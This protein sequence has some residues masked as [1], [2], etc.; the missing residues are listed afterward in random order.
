MTDKDII[1]FINQFFEIEGKCASRDLDFLERN[2]TRLIDKFDTLGFT[3]IN[4]LGEKYKE[5]RTDVNAHISSENISALKI[6]DVLK[7]IIY[8]NVGSSIELIQ[9]G[10]VI[11]G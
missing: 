9:K 1:Y 10:N 4:P 2:F 3:V 7:P 6:I 11:V 8:K 5:T